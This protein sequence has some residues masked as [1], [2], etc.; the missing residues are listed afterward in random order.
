MNV[1]WDVLCAH[2][3]L[4]KDQG[5]GTQSSSSGLLAWCGRLVSPVPRPVDPGGRSCVLL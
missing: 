3:F 4:C 2:P 1:W 5:M